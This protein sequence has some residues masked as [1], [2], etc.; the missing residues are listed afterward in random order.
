MYSHTLVYQEL[1]FRWLYR[2]A[3]LTNVYAWPTVS[4]D[5]EILELVQSHVLASTSC[6]SVVQH[7]TGRIRVLDL[8][9]RHGLEEDVRVLRKIDR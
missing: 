6:N 5:H 3:T 8:V 9:S 4:R 7:L 2:I 1:D